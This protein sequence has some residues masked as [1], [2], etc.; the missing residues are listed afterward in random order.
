MHYASKKSG[1]DFIFPKHTSNM[2]LTTTT[3]RNYPSKESVLIGKK[4]VGL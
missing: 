4:T 1:G 3:V 2:M